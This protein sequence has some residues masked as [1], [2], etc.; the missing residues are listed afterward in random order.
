[1][2]AQ[3]AMSIS[4]TESWSDEEFAAAVA[5]YSEM[6]K[7]QDTGQSVERAAIRRR[8]LEGALFRR[9]EASIEY[10]MR[11]I[12][13]VLELQGK[14]Y[15][16]GYSPARHV[17]VRGTRII[18]G[19]LEGIAQQKD[20]EQPPAIAKR[21]IPRVF[22]TG[23]WG[24]DP[25]Q[26]GY[27]GFTNVKTRD[28]LV[29][30]FEAGDFMLIV[31]QKGKI[32]DKNDVGRLLGIVELAPEPVLE[33]ERMSPAHY[34]EK[35]AQHGAERWQFALPI[36]RAWV[37]G[38]EIKASAI[39]PQSYSRN[40]ARAVG[41][42]YR[43]LTPDESARVM[44]LPVRAVGVWGEPNWKPEQQNTG[45]EASFAASISRGPNPWFGST[46]VH[47]IDGETKLYLMQLVGN[48]DALFPRLKP[49]ISQRAVIKIGRSSDPRRR[50]EELNC[51][52]PPAAEVRWKLRHAQPF[53][54][55]N[56]AHAAEQQL[57][58]DLDSRKCSI[59]KEF[60]VIPVKELD[61]LLA[62]YAG[63]S[64]FHIQA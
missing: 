55:A 31:G 34:K 20:G 4:R 10:R 14:P 37:M 11:N 36:K 54:D 51:G 48:V 58:Q 29:A 1:M 64:A 9:T 62:A 32:S 22:I 23:M 25:A 26:E 61:T 59:G 18:A 5:A 17:G 41:A 35:V 13:A 50:E 15:L 28:R 43:I 27:V 42:G 52:F 38:R 33:P 40:V 44:N 46:Q 57:L 3:G 6:L 39:L 12:S 24:F 16:S 60:A 63:P 49:T 53:K 45:G 47:R 56:D 8:L 21:S 19:L 2:Q 30:D 7:A